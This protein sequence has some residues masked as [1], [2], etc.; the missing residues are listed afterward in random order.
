MIK[1]LLQSKT[2]SYKKPWPE[3][4]AWP[5]PKFYGVKYD[6]NLDWR[7]TD[8]MKN[9]L[10]IKDYYDSLVDDG[11]LNSKYRPEVDDFYPE[12]GEVYWDDRFD[13][14]AWREELTAY[15]NLLR[16][17][18]AEPVKSIQS[19]LSYEFKNQNLLRQAFTR[20]AFQIE[21]GLDAC[22]EELEFLGDTVLSTVVTKEMFK[23][24][25]HHDYISFDSPFQSKYDEG[26]LTK[27]RQQ[28]VSKESLAAR[29]RALGL[30]Q[31]ILYGT[32]EKENDSSLEDMMEAL[33]GA[34]VMDC[35]WDMPTIEMVV[36]ELLCI[37]MD[38]SFEGFLIKSYYDE[39][40]AWH[41][42]RFGHIPSYKIYNA[43]NGKYRCEIQFNIPENDKGVQTSR[44]LSVEGET[45]SQ[46]REAAANRA[47]NDIMYQGLWRNLHEADIQ[48]DLENSINQVQELYQKK[49]LDE[50]PVYEY[51]NHGNKWTVTCHS[52]G[53]YGFGSAV[54]KVLAKKKA[55]YELMLNML[56]G[57]GMDTHKWR[58]AL[59]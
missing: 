22:S 10:V 43:S 55:S 35:N 17:P 52:D 3:N 8:Q 29:A 30:G 26:E 58:A 23:H 32:G 33:I 47:Y 12:M 44:L 19:V 25:A 54:T 21:Y 57:A 14:E 59:Q 49:Y 13:M 5:E 18:T 53:Y 51:T 16:I 7:G 2:K 6:E 48:P 24:C 40:N 15:V 45:R 20:R 46:A 56:E 28:F 39:L 37:Q 42:K 1:D 38:T 36:D 11:V 50:K 41:Q 27:V 34:V 4:C 31:Y 9:L